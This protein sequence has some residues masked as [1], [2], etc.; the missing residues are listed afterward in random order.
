[1]EPNCEPLLAVTTK[2]DAPIIL[3]PKVSGVELEN[4]QVT[5]EDQEATLTPAN[6]ARG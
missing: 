1:M 3:K 6:R 2:R 5:Y 4:V